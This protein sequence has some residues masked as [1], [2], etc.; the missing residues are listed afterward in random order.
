MLK[1]LVK[2]GNSN[3]LV[4]DKALLE[5]LNIAEGSI[6]KIKTDGVSLII[7]PQNAETQESI[8]RT[9]T[10]HDTLQEMRQQGMVQYCGNAEN[11]RV[12]MNEL[13]RIIERYREDVKKWAIPEMQ[14]ALQ[15]IEQR[16]NGNR[17]DPEYIRALGVLRQKHAPE[18]VSMDQDIQNI[19]QKYVLEKYQSKDP[20]NG[21]TFMVA[22]ADFKKVHEKYHHVLAYVAKL[23]ENAEYIHESVL[24]A[25]K[26]QTT[27][28]SP[29]YFKEYTQ[30]IAKYIPEYSAYQ[31]ELN[32]VAEA[33]NPLK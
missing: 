30:L 4:L 17:L 28:N 19:S 21:A 27:K 11:A 12:Y 22:L 2:Y 23:N 25:E 20:D 3:A 7:T 14:Q 31:D 32:K 5:L 9:I 15:A 8:T 16:F 24:L 10:P 1:K 6:V 13:D 18:L 29:E 33:M 26:Y